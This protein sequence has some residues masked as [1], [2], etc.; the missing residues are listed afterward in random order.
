MLYNDEVELNA[1][2]PLDGRYRQRVAALAACFSEA[3]L[4]K[5]RLQVELAWFMALAEADDIPELRPLTTQEVD[6][7]HKLVDTFDQSAAQTVKAIERTTNHDVKAVEYYLKQAMGPTSLAPLKEFV[8]FACTSEDINNLAHALMLKR[9]VGEIWADKAHETIDAIETLAGRYQST[10]MLAHT[11]GQPASPTTVGKEVAVFSHR[12]KRQ[13][14]QIRAQEYL[15][16]INGAVGNFNAHLV[17]YPN[18]AWPD[19]ARCFVEEKLGLTYNPLTTQIESHDYM[20]ELF[21]AIMR[22]NN[23][24]IDFD[25]DVWLYISKGYFKEKVRPGEVGS[26]TMPHKVNPIDFENSEGNLGLSNALLAFMAQKLS[27]SRLQRDL[28]DSTVIRNIGVAI[29]H[30]FLA[31][32]STLRGVGKLSVDQK[33]L[34]TDLATN[35]E[36]LSEA[37]QTVMRKAG[38]EN[39]YEQL[40]AMTRGKRINQADLRAFIQDLPLPIDD[41]TR[42]LALTPA[43]Y[44]GDAPK[45]GP[46]QDKEPEAL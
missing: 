30:S 34:Q 12:L 19:F 32:H 31:L 16:K 45:F 20:A 42:L 35:W 11:H 18:L 39:P 38:L 7:L 21:Q 6:F 2:S 14:A 24:M 26:S 29:G 41:K 10:P 44:L 5:A 36:V 37:V 15:G 27:V 33:K 8:H 1:L 22:F 40:K 28:S 13:L 46:G 4:I 9:G 23:I 3:A 43:T 17:A 25:C